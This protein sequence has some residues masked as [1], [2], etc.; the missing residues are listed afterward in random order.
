MNTTR[1]AARTLTAAIATLALVPGWQAMAQESD[2]EV[3]EEIVTI[4][5]PGGAGVEKQ[6]AS[7]AITSM[8]PD[9]IAK[10]S[11]K[12]TADLFKNVPGVWAESSG[13]VAGANIDV[14]GLPG[15]SDAPFVT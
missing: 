14:R 13:G 6:Q 10:F 2:D 11:P 4:G 3:I 5:T 15:G 8:A 7:F 1:Y 12:S 9:D